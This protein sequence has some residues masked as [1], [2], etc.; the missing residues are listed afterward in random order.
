MFKI[1]AEEKKAILKR[2]K[3]L[4]TPSSMWQLILNEAPVAPF[5]TPETRVLFHKINYKLSKASRIDPEIAEP[6]AML[7]GL[8]MRKMPA[9][10]TKNIL[11]KVAIQ[12]GIEVPHKS[13]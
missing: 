3:S 12:L 2:R 4:A 1:T 6:A 10:D 5:L 11:F 7:F 9:D 8:L 13:F